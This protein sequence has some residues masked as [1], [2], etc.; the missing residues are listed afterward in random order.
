MRER[1]I[2]DA[3]LAIADPA[4]RSAYLAAVCASDDRLRQHLEGLLAMHQQLDSFL[5]APARALVATVDERPLTEGPGTV[6][7]SYKLLEQIGEGG[8]GVVSMAKQAPPVH[9]KVAL[10]A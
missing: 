10:N 4:E 3:A 6:I 8:F 9:R 5:E 7:G 2:F 1:E